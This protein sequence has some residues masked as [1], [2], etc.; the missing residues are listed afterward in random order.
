MII[1]FFRKKEKK[2]KGKKLLAGLISAA[3]VM[4]TMILPAFANESKNPDWNANENATVVAYGIGEDSKDVYF[5]T[6]KEALNTV[7]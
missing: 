7:Y 5:T 1:K 2:A 4:G 3:M 6:I